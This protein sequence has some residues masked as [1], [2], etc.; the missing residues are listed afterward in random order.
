M[1]FH[2]HTIRYILSV[3]KNWREG[4]LNLAH[5]IKNEKARK[6]TKNE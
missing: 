1:T 2:F 3:L 4:Q 6:N 5:G